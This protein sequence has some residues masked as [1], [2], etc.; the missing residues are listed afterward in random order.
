MEEPFELSPR[1]RR[2]N[3]VMQSDTP[4]SSTALW[5]QSFCREQNARMTAMDAANQ[6]AEL[7][8]GAAVLQYNRSRQAAITQEA[9]TL[10]C[11]PQLT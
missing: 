9:P 6:N 4:A 10:R 2:L 3:N 8:A 1:L 5:L 11:I 7:T